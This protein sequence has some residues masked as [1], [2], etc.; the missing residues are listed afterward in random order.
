MEKNKT[1]PYDFT[2][3][4][5]SI[6]RM[7]D[8]FAVLDK[9]TELIE[10]IKQSEVYAEYKAALYELQKH[11]ELQEKADA[12]RTEQFQD[13]L[14]CENLI[15]FASASDMEQ[16]FEEIST[17]PEIVRFLEAELALCRLLQR[18]QNRIVEAIDFR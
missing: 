14:K 6:K 18:I 16:R 13:I 5:G 10:D 3:N 1:S 15:G 12:F 9:T 4:Y 11:P 7:K 2:D 8:M 17:Y